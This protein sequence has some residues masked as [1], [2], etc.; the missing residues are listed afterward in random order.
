MKIAVSPRQRREPRFPMEYRIRV[1]GFDRS[2]L[3]FTEETA[4]ID[5]SAN[6]C[7][8]RLRTPVH[9]GAFVAISLMGDDPRA[10]RALYSVVWYKPVD[11]G[12]ELGLERFT[13]PNIWGFRFPEQPTGNW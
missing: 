7:R 8:L 11:G 12:Y 6:G 5:I 3:R 9:R 4:T 1:G 10:P 13:G 2:G